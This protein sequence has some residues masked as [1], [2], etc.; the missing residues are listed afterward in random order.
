M[1]GVLAKVYP[2]GTTGLNLKYDAE[3][4]FGKNGYFDYTLKGL[5]S[6]CISCSI[7]VTY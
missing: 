2:S 3:K 5:V 6:L 1:N 4:I 7:A